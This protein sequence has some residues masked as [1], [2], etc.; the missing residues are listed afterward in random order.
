M[1]TNLKKWIF[2]PF[3][4]GISFC[5]SLVIYVALKLKINIE[6]HKCIKQSSTFVF[7]QESL[8]FCYSVCGSWNVPWLK[9]SFLTKCRIFEGP[10]HDREHSLRWGA[11]PGQFG[12]LSE[13]NDFRCHKQVTFISLCAYVICKH[14]MQ[15]HINTLGLPQQTANI[16]L[17]LYLSSCFLLLCVI[18]MELTGQNN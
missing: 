1:Q 18:P 7:F 8:F 11:Q 16:S 14:Y 5:S 6:V 2:L 12:F 13:P 3:P 15:T 9:N 17:C 10:L 4:F